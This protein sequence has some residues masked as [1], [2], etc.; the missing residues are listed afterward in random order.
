MIKNDNPS[1]SLMLFITNVV[2]K[3]HQAE[4]RKS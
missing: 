1:K 4:E 3:E 2:F